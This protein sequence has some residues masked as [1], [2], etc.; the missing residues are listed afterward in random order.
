MVR[1]WLD[2]LQ[3]DLTLNRPV[4]PDIIRWLST[5]YRAYHQDDIESDHPNRASPVDSREGDDQLAQL[6]VGWWSRHISLPRIRSPGRRIVAFL[7]QSRGRNAANDLHTD[8]VSR[9][10]SESVNSIASQLD[11]GYE[12]SYASQVAGE[13]AFSIQQQLW[14]MRERTQETERGRQSRGLRYWCSKAKARTQG[15]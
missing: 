7:R 6:T 5:T 9:D 13:S 14:V 10:T 4:D 1:E 8:I 3:A 11:E 12:S 15:V 2:G